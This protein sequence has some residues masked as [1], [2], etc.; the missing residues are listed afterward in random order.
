MDNLTLVWIAFSYVY[1]GAMFFI[2]YMTGKA[3]LR[4]STAKS[5]RG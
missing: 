2:G 3:L 4:N 1:G 5:P